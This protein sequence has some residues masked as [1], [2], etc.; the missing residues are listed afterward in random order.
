METNEREITLT[1]QRS[2]SLKKGLSKLRVEI[3]W[4]PN[5]RA[6]RN[7]NYDFDVDLI[8]VELNKNGKCPSPDHLVFILAYFK[9]RMEC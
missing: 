3:V 1:K 5:S 2:V 4:K 8:T 6:L 7:S 9:L